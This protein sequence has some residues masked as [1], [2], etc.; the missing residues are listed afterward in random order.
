MNHAISANLP[1]NELAT[2]LLVEAPAQG[3][4]NKPTLLFSRRE[5]KSIW[6]SFV[7]WLT[8]PIQ[9][10]QAK[11]RVAEVIA[12][13][14]S[15]DDAVGIKSVKQ[16]SM[17]MQQAGLLK[18]ISAQTA[19][20]A[21]IDL[22]IHGKDL[23]DEFKPLLMDFLH[24]AKQH[25]C[26]QINQRFSSE[27]NK[28]TLIKDFEKGLDVLIEFALD[29][30]CSLSTEENELAQKF[31]DQF[32][33]SH[34][35]PGSSLQKIFERYVAA[36]DVPN[37]QKSK[38]RIVNHN[39][40]APPTPVQRKEASQRQIVALN[41]LRQVF[42]KAEQLCIDAFESFISQDHE[43]LNNDQRLVL[44]RFL[45]TFAD[46][47]LQLPRETRDNLLP[48]VIRAEDALLSSPVKA[49]STASK[50]AETNPWDE[51]L[52]DL[53]KLQDPWKTVAQR[54]TNLLDETGVFSP[55]CSLA[56]I[57][58]LCNKAKLMPLT[59]AVRQQEALDQ[60]MRKEDN[61]LLRTQKLRT[62]RKKN[63]ISSRAKKQVIAR[64]IRHDKTAVT[65]VSKRIEIESLTRQLLNPESFVRLT[66]VIESEKMLKS[67]LF[68]SEIEREEAAMLAEV[69]TALRA[70]L[71][72]YA[73]ARLQ[74]MG[75]ATPSLS[76]PAP[77]SPR[78]GPAISSRSDQS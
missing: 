68:D 78:Q 13:I 50:P 3:S 67:R 9:R 20:S 19:K 16:L 63:V 6:Q 21:L 7:D 35:E 56:M 71:V 49:G 69:M 24:N 62:L 54:F 17:E 57:E 14:S 75:L 47:F 39:Q 38:N 41:H 52:P 44:D 37:D 76:Q 72:T 61:D 1:R 25:Y 26:Q 60:R 31:I 4:S 15:D 10:N 22:M 40:S 55:S 59:E 2:E 23:D 53:A 65:L 48:M 8:R 70:D 28:D 5:E 58:Y 66:Y 27:I 51:S 46:Q 43:E 30:N 77:A 32:V 33:E 36:I 42:P 11:A 74:P 12:K 73:K 29:P 45:V 34:K 18:G 64:S